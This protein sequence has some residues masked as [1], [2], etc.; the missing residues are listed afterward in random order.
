M[1]FI[2]SYIENFIAGTI[3]WL[4]PL[5]L[6]VLQFILKL[7][8]CEKPNGITLRNSF[9]QIPIDLGF[10]SLSFV[11][12]LIIIK[13]DSVRIIIFTI[14]IIF[15]ILIMAFWKLSPS[16]ITRKDLI[17]T[18]IFTTINYFLSIVMIIYGINLMI[19]V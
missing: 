13:P 9:M 1:L 10:L 16:N 14:Y 15:F 11:S 7:L 8:I 18:S 19:G 17:I 4:M 3:Q 12:A 6:L 2:L 5:I